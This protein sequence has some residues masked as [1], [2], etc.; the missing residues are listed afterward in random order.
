MLRLR[1]IG[2]E[3]VAEAYYQYY[4]S[5]LS[6]LENVVRGLGIG[7]GIVVTY[8]ASKINIFER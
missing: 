5:F 3:T 8:I 4:G 2:G 7:L 1:S 6:G